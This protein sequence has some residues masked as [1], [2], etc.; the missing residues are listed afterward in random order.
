MSHALRLVRH[1]RTDSP[2][3]A[4]AS[5]TDRAGET[6]RNGYR[7][8]EID[9][10]RRGMSF[11]SIPVIG[12]DGRIDMRALNAVGGEL[13]L[14]ETIDPT[15]VINVGDELF[16]SKVTDLFVLDREPSPE[17]FAFSYELADGRFGTAVAT[18]CA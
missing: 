5:E 8:N 9:S 17:R 7:F 2:A 1:D 11:M 16:G 13:R 4:P 3:F 10:P 14:A 18:R 6:R 12:K 15:R